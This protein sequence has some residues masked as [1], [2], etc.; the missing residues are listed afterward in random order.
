[1][2]NRQTSWRSR[3]DYVHWQS[4]V[5]VKLKRL[6]RA[7]LPLSLCLACAHQSSCGKVGLTAHDFIDARYMIL[8][9]RRYYYLRGNPMMM[10]RYAKPT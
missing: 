8:L 4:Y 10:A 7:H 3:V 6:S 1:M 2:T 5:P 9:T